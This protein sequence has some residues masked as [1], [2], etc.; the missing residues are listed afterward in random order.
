MVIRVNTNNN[1]TKLS[2]YHF[3]DKRLS[4][5]AKGLLSLMLSLP[6]NWDYSVEGLS[7][8][9]KESSG[10]I[11]NILDELREYGY[12]VITKYYPGTDN[13]SRIKYVYDIYEQALDEPVKDFIE[14]KDK[15]QDI[16]S[17]GVESQG[18]ES[19][20]VVSQVLENQGQ[21]ITN[22]LNNTTNKHINNNIY[23]NSSIK[24]ESGLQPSSSFST[25][26]VSSH[27]QLLPGVIKKKNTDVKNHSIGVK[28]KQKID[29]L[30]LDLDISRALYNWIDVLVSLK[31]I[32]SSAQMDLCL[33]DLLNIMEEIKQK[34]TILFIIEQTT[35]NGYLSFRWCVPK[36]NNIYNNK[37]TY[38]IPCHENQKDIT[39][40]PGESRQD[41]VQ[42][43]LKERIENGAKGY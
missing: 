43:E 25:N 22:I 2:N 11:K 4:L 42:R 14:I 34:D 28:Y 33:N 10:Y 19:Q 18:V 23:N 29:K 31:K 6:D 37:R 40:K 21:S 13:N 26:V 35:I 15:Q 9:C 20:G 38:D 36:S 32:P 1:Y 8:I 5:K 17:Q 39:M 12:L 3:K 30:N 7:S 24:K 41:A 16:N 27:K